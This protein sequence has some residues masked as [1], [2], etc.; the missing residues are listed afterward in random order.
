MAALKKDM[1]Q[2][3]NNMKIYRKHFMAT[4][5]LLISILFVAVNFSF[6]MAQSTVELKDA[7]FV[8]ALKNQFPQVIDENNNLII[9]QANLISG[10]IAFN[11]SG[12]SDISGIEYFINITALDVSNNNLTVIPS[13]VTLTKLEQLTCSNNQLTQLPDLNVFNNLKYINCNYN[14]ITS[15]PVL[16]NL[17]RLEQLLA[18]NNQLS[19][20]SEFYKPSLLIVL[21]VNNNQLVSIPDLSTF[22]SLTSLNLTHNQL[23]FTVLKPTSNHPLFNLFAVFPQDSVGAEQTIFFTLNQNIV[24]KTT[25]DEAL[26]TITYSWYKNNVFIAKTA[27]DDFPLNNIQYTDSGEYTCILTYNQAGS[28]L[29]TKSIVTKP[30]HVIFECP[31]L[32]SVNFTIENTDCTLGTSIKIDESF[33]LSTKA[34]Y[35]YLLTNTI[36]NEKLSAA[37]STFQHLKPGNYKLQI[38]DVQ[39]VC[40]TSV[41]KAIVIEKIMNCETSTNVFSPDGDGFHDHYF[42]ENTGNVEIFNRQGKLVKRLSVPANWDGT[43]QAGN[44]LDLGYYVIVINGTT[45]LFVTLLQ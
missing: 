6:S 42:I 15:L 8:T 37:T 10:P 27:T 12:L 7:A 35:E 9:V 34:P 45:K 29:F 16:T 41:S 40:T 31:K 17:T 3:M 39:K 26:T 13:I 1:L 36:T 23:T 28:L 14:K 30:I 20:L 44:V 25:V 33:T 22:S 21:E 2:F 18:S 38:T 43:D 32:N 19:S 11:N 4:K 24:L 5:L